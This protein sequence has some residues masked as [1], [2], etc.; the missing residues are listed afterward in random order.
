MANVF[1]LLNDERHAGNDE[2][3]IGVFVKKEN[4]EKAKTQCAEAG[5][6]DMHIEEIGLNELN[7]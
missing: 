2:R 7:I 4:A 1:V 6:E 5:Y 3:L